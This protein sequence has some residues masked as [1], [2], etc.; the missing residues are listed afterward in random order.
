MK[1]TTP[2]DL[3]TATD[4][5]LIQLCRHG[6]QNAYGQ[7]VERYQTLACSVGYNCCGDLALSEDLAQ[8]GFILAWQKLGDLKDD[9][10]F[11]AWICTIVRNLA[12]RSSQ[13]FGRSVTHAAAHLDA[14]VDIPSDIET[15]VERAVSLEEEKLV[16]QALADVPENY[17]EPLILFYREE[18]S[19]ARVAEALD[20]SEDAVKQR[21]SRGRKMLRQHLA[22]VVESAL[23]NSKPAKAFTGAVLLGLSS[24]TAKSAAAAGV[25]T[26]TATV[27]KSAAGVG[28]GSG[29]SSLL[30]GP[31]LNL[32]VLAWLL[33]IAFDD[34]RSERERRLLHRNL[35][36][37]FCGLVVFAATVFSSIWWQQYIEPPLLRACLPGA[38][39][40]VFLIPWIVF[41]RQMGKRIERIRIE[42]GTF[43]P[44]RPLVESEN[45]GPIALKVYGLFCLSSL[46]VMAGPAI[47]PFV[48]HDWLVLLAMFVSA[49]CISLIAA[50]I[51]LRLPKWSFQL[52]GA[53]TG[54]TALATL[55]IMFWRQSVWASAFADFLPWFIGTMSALTMTQLIATTIAWKRAY[56]KPKSQGEGR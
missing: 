10:K 17:R 33:K 38:M 43:S 21:L 32:P 39:M 41:S 37:G 40:V 29:L 5:E 53:G 23:A 36:F 48:A 44:P 15:P 8:D 24:A 4:S 16:W 49:I 13:R 9:S 51:S 31:I 25:T 52:F 20:L 35:L 55:G 11:K 14:V 42:E 18:Q 22:A 27:A 34:T 30:L 56:G 46:L 7:I 45:G 19:V 28:A 50:Q 3:C 6:N 26:A 12:N 54:L 2:I 47:L 1:T